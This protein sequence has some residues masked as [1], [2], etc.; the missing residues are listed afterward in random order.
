MCCCLFA[1]TPSVL[2]PEQEVIIIPDWTACRVSGELAYN[3]DR[4]EKRDYATCLVVV[5]KPSSI[6]VPFSARAHRGDALCLLDSD[7]EPTRTLGGRYVNPLTIDYKMILEWISSCQ[8]LHNETCLPV[9]TDE[10]REIR[11]IDVET[12]EVVKYQGPSCEFVALSYVW[13]PIK[14]ETYRL[15]DT[16]RKL[17]KTLEDAIAFTKE[18]GKRF[19][20]ID[21]VCIDQSSDQDKANQI[22]R[23]WS[24]YRGAWVTLIALSAVSAEEGL[25]R[26]SRK[27][28][29]PQVH[30]KIKGKSLVGLMPT[31]SQQ[32][33]QCPWGRRAWTLQEGLLTPRCLYISDHQAYYD[34]AAT[35]CCESLDQTRSWG[36]NLSASSTPIGEQFLP[37]ME[38]QVGSGGLR[39]R[40]DEPSKRLEQMGLNLNLYSY[41]EMTFDIDALKA[42]EGILQKFN[43]M[44]PK[45]Y[46][47]GSAVEDFDWALLWRSQTPPTRRPGFPSWSFTGW[48]GPL[49]FGQPFDIKLTRWL[50]TNVDIMVCKG[51]RLE[52]IF[53]LHD[54]VD[55]PKSISIMIQNDAIDKAM[56]MDCTDPPF[57]IDEHPTAERLGQLFIT[58]ACFHFMPDF[59]KPIRHMEVPGEH[60]LFVTNVQG[61]RCL[62]RITCT[63]RYIPGRWDEDEWVLEPLSQEMWTCILVARDHIEGHIVHHLLVLDTNE[64]RCA[65]E[66]KTVM[67]LLIPLEHLDVLDEF[68]IRKR[69][70]IMK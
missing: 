36:H 10:L 26:M 46:F 56:Q 43:S 67:E 49:Y 33:W 25:P 66:R 32:I 37:W 5:L 48:K 28:I 35:Q 22:G 27:E 31:L 41:R 8:M 40:L 9:H 6:L 16:L 34:C 24:I 64:T 63:D 45:G 54:G 14:P 52:Q 47:W 57:N 65:A 59:R 13:G 30:C 44:Y 61:V 39:L 3:S 7:L 17:P 23:M 60:E 69:R 21:S 42:F 11:L 12:K 4:P 29:F 18:L 1:I 53:P 19:I 15:H 58:A 20:W 2:S 55:D 38:R 50:P 62:I 68:V 51:G 70:I